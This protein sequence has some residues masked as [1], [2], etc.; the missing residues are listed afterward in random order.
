MAEINQYTISLREVAEATITRQKITT[1]KWVVGVNFGV[2]VGNLGQSSEKDAK[3][4]VAVIIDCFTL[5]RLPE[6]QPVPKEMEAIVVDAAA[7]KPAG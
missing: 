3:P 7:I 1:G 5:T 6:G 2:Q 4:G